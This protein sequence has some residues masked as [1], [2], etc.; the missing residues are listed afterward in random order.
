[1]GTGGIGV[2]RVGPKRGTIEGFSPVNV[3]AK[4]GDGGELAVTE[5]MRRQKL[6]VLN[7]AK[8]LNTQRIYI[9]KGTNFIINRR[10]S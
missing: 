3:A 7:F 8:D 6:N 9:E 4:R 10:R 5:K 1:V 2:S